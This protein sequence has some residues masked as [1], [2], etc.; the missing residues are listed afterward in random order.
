MARKPIGKLKF[1]YKNHNRISPRI[2]GPKVALNMLYAWMIGCNI[3]CE[4]H[5]RRINISID[6]WADYDVRIMDG[7]DM[8]N[9]IFYH[10]FQERK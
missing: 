8:I 10:N 3:P 4:L 7:L 2:S 6:V 5:K 1:T 9:D